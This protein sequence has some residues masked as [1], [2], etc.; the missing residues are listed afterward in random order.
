[1]NQDDWYKNA[2]YRISAVGVICND[3]GEYLM[4]NEHNRWSFPGGGWDYG[5]S[6]HEALK[7]E[8][9]EEIAL[10]SDF[11]EKVITAIP[12]YNPNKEAWQMWVACKI[13]YDELIFSVGEHA[14][15]TRWMNEDEI[16]YSTMAGK[17]MQEVLTIQKNEKSEIISTQKK[18]PDLPELEKGI[19]RHTKSGNIYEVIAVTFH[20]ETN[21]PLVLYKPLYKSK[22]EVFARPYAMFTETIKLN[23][24]TRP[25]FQKVND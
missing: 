17:L 21:E 15:A 19:Y 9:F 13:T 23:G 1:M 24:K 22:Y 7:R 12:F 4:V 11:S 25:R 10:K 20:T 3:K 16:D 2:F 18:D 14:E 6:L 5:E 8:L